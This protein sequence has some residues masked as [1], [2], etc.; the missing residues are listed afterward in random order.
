MQPA[1][2]VDSLCSGTFVL[3]V[4]QHH[5]HTPAHQFTRN[6]FRVFRNH[7]GFH[8]GH[9]LSARGVQNLIP[10]AVADKRRTLR[11]TVCNGV[12]EVDFTQKGFHFGVERC[13][14]NY[15]FDKVSTEHFHGLLTNL[16]LD[17]IADDRQVQQQFSEL[18]V[19]FRENVFLENLFHNQRHAGN[20]ARTDYSKRFCNDF[21]ARH[22]GEEPQM[23]SSGDAVKKIEHQS[24]DMSQ[25]KHGY[26]AV[27]RFQSYFLVNVYDV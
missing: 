25:R 1:V 14:S 26:D 9:G 18:V 3:V 27:A 16:F 12:G 11:H 19:H 6:P 4:S 21:R 7:L 2:L 24:E 13:S 15:D 8:V 10:A 20:D 17:F 23:C 22:T 5:V